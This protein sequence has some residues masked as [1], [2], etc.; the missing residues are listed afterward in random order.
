MG[1]IFCLDPMGDYRVCCDVYLQ[2]TSVYV[3]MTPVG[4]EVSPELGAVE[5]PRPPSGSLSVFPQESCILLSLPYAP[6][7]KYHGPFHL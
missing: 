4:L 1:L 6:L 2:H 7:H 3:L 5:K